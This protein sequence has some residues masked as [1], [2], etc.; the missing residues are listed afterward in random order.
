M[1]GDILFD[2][3]CENEFEEIFAMFCAATAEMERQGI[4]QWD[5]IYPDRDILRDDIIKRQLFIGKISDKIVCAYALNSEC[6]EEYQLGDWKYPIQDARIVHRLCV[7]PDYQHQG[8]AK[9]TMLHVER[10]AKKLGTLSIRL[11]AFTQNP[12][13]LRLY[14]RL[15]YNRVGIAAWRKGNFYLMEKLI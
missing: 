12:H 6:D 7:H 11:D 5:E 4:Y 10:Q 3:A 2:C 8:I 14:E 1:N 15:G 9:Q 13:A